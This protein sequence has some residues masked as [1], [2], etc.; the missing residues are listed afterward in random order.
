MSIEVFFNQKSHLFEKEMTLSAF[1][2]TKKLQGD[3]FAVLIN[4]QFIPRD[5]YD[6][7]ILI[8]GDHIEMITPMQGG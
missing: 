6:R 5:Q 3:Y 4:D 2:T 1:L 8:A 7:R